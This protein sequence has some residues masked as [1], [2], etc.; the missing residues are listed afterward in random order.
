MKGSIIASSIIELVIAG[1]VILI[2]SFLLS[3]L[4]GGFIDSEDENVYT[5]RDL[6]SFTDSVSKNKCAEMDFN[7]KSG[8]RIEH[9]SNKL[10]LIK[11]GNDGPVTSVKMKRS[12][13]VI[14]NKIYN[15]IES[16]LPINVDFSR[17]ISARSCVCNNDGKVTL[18]KMPYQYGIASGCSLIDTVSGAVIG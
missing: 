1:I 3:N 9:N 2:G 18:S 5:V 12:I 8:Y 10:E 6:A 16:N 13:M 15:T 11:D 17:D 14:D 4:F 7:L